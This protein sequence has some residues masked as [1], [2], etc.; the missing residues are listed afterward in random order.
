MPA[1][2]S[3]TLRTENPE[4]PK[5]LE[6]PMLLALTRDV[7]PSFNRCELTHLS[8]Q[9]IDVALARE[10]HAAYERALAD[11]GCDVR[12]L[13]AGD[14]LPDSV[15]IEDTAVVVDEMAIVGRPGVASRRGEP[16]AVADALA[17]YRPVR[18][19]EAPGVLEGGDVL[20]M[21]R[22]V[23]VG[24]SGRTNA[25]GV[26]QLRQLLESIGYT[27]IAVPVSGCLH[28]KSAVSAIGDALVLMNSAWV[29][30][31]P[32]GDCDVVEVDPAEPYAANAVRIRGRVVYP[33]SFPQ[34]RRAI[35]ASGLEV[36]VV[37][38]SELQKAEGAV[39]C[40][41]VIFRVG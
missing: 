27:V 29:P 24:S 1:V 30:R 36:S 5:N 16:A 19:I 23:F 20:I 33:A 26:E 14:D 11:A 34:T 37:D 32:F 41:S 12:R 21:G 39:T 40:C 4:N 25:S 10:Q 6:N 38:V 9:P 2:I 8:R 22:R 28:L 3:R 18:W 31:E 13:D 17:A 7:N 15:F 35:E